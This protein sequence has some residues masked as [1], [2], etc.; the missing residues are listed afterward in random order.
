MKADEGVCEPDKTDLGFY[1][2]GE[3]SLVDGLK[4]RRVWGGSMEGHGGVE[5]LQ[6]LQQLYRKSFF[7]TKRPLVV[8][9]VQKF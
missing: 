2:K 7:G 6:K 1:E 3:F 9:H 5:G 4:P 8:N